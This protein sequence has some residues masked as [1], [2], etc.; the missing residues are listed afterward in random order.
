MTSK[1]GDWCTVNWEI[2]IY[3]HY[4]RS[5]EVKSWTCLC[6]RHLLLCMCIFFI[7]RVQLISYNAKGNV[8]NKM[9]SSF[10]GFIFVDTK[11]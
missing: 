2:Y 1:N 3:V 4:K 5:G 10:L 9:C 7:T 6:A 11:I 8:I